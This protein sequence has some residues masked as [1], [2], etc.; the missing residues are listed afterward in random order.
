MPELPEVETIKSQLNRFLPL[1]VTDFKVS[2]LSTSI[3]KQQDFQPIGKVIT[4][5]ERD[6]KVLKFVFEEDEYYL[7]S[8]LGMTGSWQISKNLSQAKH[9]HITFVCKDFSNQQETWYLQYEDPRRFGKSYF[10][11]SQDY[12]KWR[13]TRIGV[14]VSKREDFTLEYL[15]QLKKR[16]P[17][18]V[19]KPFLLE[20]KFFGGIGNYMASEILA[21]SKIRPT[22][23]MKSL[24]KKE[25]NNLL[26]STD[27]VIHD[28]A[29]SNGLTFSGGYKDAFGEKGQGLS[30]LIIFHQEVCQQCLKENSVKKIVQAQRATFYC[31]HCQK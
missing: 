12:H 22:R 18:K 23:K 13:K 28:Q 2:N 19:I 11:H 4:Q 7:V 9:I 29:K 30:N 26:V 24:T 31:P 21:F 8:G 3:I 25:L 20:Q 6:A 27:K 10:L 16:F 14:D 5:I 15:V 17:E 1:V